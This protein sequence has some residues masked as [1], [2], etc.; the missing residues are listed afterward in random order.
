[1][2]STCYNRHNFSSQ[3][4][5]QSSDPALYQVPQ[6]NNLSGRTMLHARIHTHTHK[7]K[8]NILDNSK[9]II[10]IILQTLSTFYYKFI[11]ILLSFSVSLRTSER[12]TNTDS[13]ILQSKRKPNFALVGWNAGHFGQLLS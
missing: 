11:F 13:F 6:Q 8:M 12:K 3:P 2:L 4:K 7:I 9:A 1:M 5:N 10:N